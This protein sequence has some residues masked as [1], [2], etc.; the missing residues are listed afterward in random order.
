MD[1]TALNYNADAN[2]AANED[3]VYGCDGEYATVV[4][5]TASWAE[6]ITWNLLDDLGNIILSG[7]PYEDYSS[8]EQDVCLALGQYTFQVL[9]SYGDG[10]NGGGNFAVNT[11]CG[12]IT[13]AL[14]DGMPQGETEEFLFSVISCSQVTLCLSASY[15]II[16]ISRVEYVIKFRIHRE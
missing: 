3:C 1:E 10:W 9:D 14:A 2:T 11:T 16:R 12:D 5:N 7:G 6:E 15:L 8:S 13:I 4:I